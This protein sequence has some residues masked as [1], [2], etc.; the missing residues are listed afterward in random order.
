MIIFT[1]LRIALYI[2]VRNAISK[3]IDHGQ[4]PSL[5]T[6]VFAG[7]GTGAFAIIIANPADVVKIRLQAQNRGGGG[8]NVVRYEGTFDCY[9][10]IIAEDGI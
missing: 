7:L 9:K 1:G 10:K 5:L 6:K 3:K 8:W 4:N 2:P